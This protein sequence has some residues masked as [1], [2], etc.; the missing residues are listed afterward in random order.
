MRCVLLHYHIFKNAGSTVEEIFARSFG[1]SLARMET[2]AREGLISHHDILEFL[3]GNPYIK[4]I[5]SHQ[6]RYPVPQ[7]PGYLFLDLC[8]LRD[9]IDR[10]RSIYDFYHSR[11]AAGDPL[12][13]L[14]RGSIAEFV[15]GVVGEQQLHIKNAQ[16]NLLACLGDSDDPEEK[17]FHVA[18]ERIRK[19]AFLGVVDHFNKS[20]VAGQYAVQAVFPELDCA[21]PAEN[22]TGGM[23]GDL[24]RRVS[25]VRAACDESDYEELL[26]LNA[27][28]LRLLECARFEVSRRFGLVPDAR[29]KLE[30]FE[31]RISAPPEVRGSP[32]MRCRRTPRASPRQETHTAM[33]PAPGVLTRLRRLARAPIDA[34]TIWRSARSGIRLFDSSYYSESLLH[35]LLRGAFEGRKPHSLFDPGFYLRMYPDVAASGANPLGHYL[36]CGAQEKRQPNPFFDPVFYL[37]RN[38]DVRCAGA[39]PFLHYLRHGANERRKPHPV[40]QPQYYAHVCAGVPIDAGGLLAHFAESGSGAA[41]PHPLFDCDSYLAHHPELA[42]RDFNPLADYLSTLCAKPTRGT[43]ELPAAVPRAAQLVLDDVP[44]IIVF[45][46][47]WPRPHEDRPLPIIDTHAASCRLPHSLVVVSRDPSGAVHVHAEPQQQPFFDAIPAEQ[48]YAQVNARLASD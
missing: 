6:I 12:S 45:Q 34:F 16:V 20:M 25:R 11:P 47:E 35:F 10:V 15:S 33:I 44:V 21:Q 36:R 42:G 32:F 3:E 26:R 39:P 28:D 46:G 2:P 7:A 24:A 19:A 30:E 43:P 8:I 40:F 29:A 23:E 1:N 37:E 9:P 22:V 17:D 38:P 27:L 4:A 18:F 14:A 13:D 48:L 41:S 31:R 5:S